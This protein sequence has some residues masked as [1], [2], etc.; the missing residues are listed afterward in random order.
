MIVLAS[1]ASVH[2][3]KQV[4]LSLSSSLLAMRFLQKGVYDQ[5]NSGRIEQKLNR[6]FEVRLSR[7][8][9]TGV[10]RASLISCDREHVTLPTL[11][12]VLYLFLLESAVFCLSL[13]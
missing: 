11:P 9:L 4:F 1:Q 5:C 7:L 3:R 10:P 8:S 2:C 13:T 6:K 12:L